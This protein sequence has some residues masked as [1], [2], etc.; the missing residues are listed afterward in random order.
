MTEML[1]SDLIFY[2]LIVLAYFAALAF[3]GWL[4]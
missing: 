1:N 2:S 3:F 4:L